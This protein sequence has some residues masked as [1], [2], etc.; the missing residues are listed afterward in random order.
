MISRLFYR[1][2]LF[3]IFVS[4]SFVCATTQAQEKIAAN[5][6]L[7]SIAPLHA[8]V[9]VVTEGVTEPGLLLKSQYSPHGASLKPSERRMLFNAKIVFYIDDN[10]ET[11]LPQLF[12]SHTSL[13]PV[14]ISQT[15]N[16]TLLP[17]R[18]SIGG[19]H[20]HRA[21]R[22]QSYQLGELLARKVPS[23]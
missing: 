20:D 2:V 8:L 14:Q 12:L 13:K 9:S 15:K 1:L 4:S 10:F 18:E 7:V 21:I 17:L 19:E 5:E 6:I 3:S 22:L 11:F 23:P 16:L